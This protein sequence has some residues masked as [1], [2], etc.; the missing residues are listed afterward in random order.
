MIVLGRLSIYYD[1]KFKNITNIIPLWL[2]LVTT[3]FDR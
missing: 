3:G 1:G 2:L